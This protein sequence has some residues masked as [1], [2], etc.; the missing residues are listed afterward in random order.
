MHSTSQQY[1]FIWLLPSSVCVYAFTKTLC[2]YFHWLTE[3]AENYCLQ[4]KQKVIIVHDCV[5]L[6]WCFQLCSLIMQLT[7][8]FD[9]Q[10]KGCSA[11]SRKQCTTSWSQSWN[12]EAGDEVG[13]SLQSQP[14]ASWRSA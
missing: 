7:V 6:G 12:I 11:S 3:S 9:L 13:S 2:I 1:L 4:H 5:A 10:I 14:V 8:L